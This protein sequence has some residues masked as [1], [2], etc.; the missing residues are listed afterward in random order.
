MDDQKIEIENTDLISEEIL[1]DISSENL[2]T[3]QDMMRVGLMYGHKKSKTNPKFRNYI[4]ITRNGIEIIDL[5]QTLDALDKAI[6][7]L[8]SR[9]KEGNK[10]LIVATQ[11]AAREK[12]ENLAKKFNF[13]FINERWIGG[14]LT[15]F[16]VISGRIEYF[17]KIKNDF[18][19]GH[20][21][22]YT[23]KER[24]MIDR[25]IVRM[26]KMFS[27]L[28]NMER[29]PDVVF[30]IDTSLKNHATALREARL[31]KIKTI[32]VIDSD[33]DPEVIDY[34][35]PAND[36][37]KPGIDWIIDRISERLVDSG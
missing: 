19:K 37:S 21:E 10:I 15:N 24:L 14:L 1:E 4:H 3:L 11:P 34:P 13:S 23:K 22:K 9:V 12:I 20:F 7:F 32:A 29:L 2:S 35:I 8:K 28:E 6:E 27:G 25:D 5:S 31:L 30:I 36:H 16:K 26:E 17:K 18:E 33:D